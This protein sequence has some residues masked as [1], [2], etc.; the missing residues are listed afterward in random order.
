MPRF[1]ILRIKHSVSEFDLCSFSSGEL[2][3]FLQ[4]VVIEI[5]WSMDQQQELSP[6]SMLNS[7]SRSTLF[8]T[9]YYNFRAH[10]IIFGNFWANSG[11]VS[12]YCCILHQTALVPIIWW[13]LLLV[14]VHCVPQLKETG[15]GHPRLY[16]IFLSVFLKM[17]AIIQQINHPCS[18]RSWDSNSWS[19][20]IFNWV[21]ENLKCITIFI[22]ADQL[23]F[24]LTQNPR[25]QKYLQC[26]RRFVDTIK[27]HKFE[28]RKSWNSES[29]L[30][31]H[32]CWTCTRFLIIFIQ[33]KNVTI[34]NVYP[35][36]NFVQGVE[37]SYRPKL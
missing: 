6:V 2:E 1:S 35:W 20:K 19:V 7:C 15:R 18:I 14:Q 37:G 13:I 10:N 36:S 16:F 27:G 33:R 5:Y 32:F 8:K 12:K 22:P 29:V 28:S 23:I 25:V 4:N 11:Q 26:G 24:R 9:K 17:N 30:N 21:I 31:E 3:Q 34:L